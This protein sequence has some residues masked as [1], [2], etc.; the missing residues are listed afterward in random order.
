M[1]VVYEADLIREVAVLSGVSERMAR[2]MLQSIKEV[3]DR[4]IMAGEKVYMM[5][6]GLYSPKRVS[7]KTLRN[8]QTGKAVHVRAHLCPA[9]KPSEKIRTA[10]RALR[11]PP[12]HKKSLR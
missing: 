9:W 1:N 6:H 5:S 11:V 3:L 4:H 8:P 10:L 2:L 7:A 12:R